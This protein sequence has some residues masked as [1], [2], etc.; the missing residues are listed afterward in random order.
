MEVF[1]K[2]D[3]GEEEAPAEEEEEGAAAEKTEETDLL[4]T[5]KYKYVPEVVKDPK[6]HFYKVPRLGCYMAIPLIYQSCMNESSYDTALEDYVEVSKQMEEVNKKR[7][8]WRATLEHEREEA[9]KNGTEYKE[10]E[11]PEDFRDDILT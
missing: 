11:I 5:E 1:G 7:E 2:V 10:P 8:E 9:A 6:I 4:K 3:E